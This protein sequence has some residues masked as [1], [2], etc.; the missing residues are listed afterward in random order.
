MG[1]AKNPSGHQI[2]AGQTLVLGQSAFLRTDNGTAV[3][4]INGTAAGTP[5]PIWDGE[6]TYWTPGDQGSSE[7]YAAHSGTYGWDSSPTSLGQD[8]KFDHGDNFDVTVYD[9]IS[10]WMQ[11]KAYPLDSDLQIL[12]KTAAG[13]T[14]GNV[15]SVED[16]VANMD[17]DVWQKVSI[18]ISDFAIPDDVD[19]VLLKYAN[20]GGQQ[21]WF[22]DINLNTGGGGGPFTFRVASPDANTFYH[23]SMLVVLLAGASTGWNS[24]AFASITGGITNGLLLRQRRISTAEILWSINARDNIELFGRYHPQD[25]ITFADSV[26]LTGFMLKPGKASIIVTNDDV[27]EFIVRDN[28]STISAARAFVNYGVEIAEAEE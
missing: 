16:Y 11:P 25:N 14:K 21:F 15:L 23:V 7:T 24:D 8:T 1:Y 9:E 2:Y 18:P 19:K 22:D 3:M 17:L 20:K 6:G 26:L 12:W 5:V 4:N 13:T 10:F 28:L 27:L